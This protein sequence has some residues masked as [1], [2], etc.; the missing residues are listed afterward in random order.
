MMRMSCCLAG[1]ELSKVLFLCTN[2]L[3]CMCVCRYVC[4]KYESLCFSGFLVYFFLLMAGYFSFLVFFFFF[5]CPLLALVNSFNKPYLCLLPG[6]PGQNKLVILL[7]LL[8]EFSK[9]SKKGPL[10]EFFFFFKSSNADGML[11]K[12][13]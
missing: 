4:N 11:D 8:G 5:F 1:L 9:N 12:N 2:M 3:L 6:I 7:G 10:W 13:F